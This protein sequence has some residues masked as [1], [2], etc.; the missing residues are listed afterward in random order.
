VS[1]RPF[2]DCPDT[3][4]TY[5]LLLDAM[6]AH[7]GTVLSAATSRVPGILPAC[8]GSTSVDDLL[9]AVTRTLFDHE[10]T[11]AVVAGPPADAARTADAIFARTK[12]PRVD[13]A[14]ADFL[15][16]LGGDS[17]GA[18]LDAKRGIPEY[19][20]QGATLI[21]AV[22]DVHLSRPA[23]PNAVRLSGPGI[24][25]PRPPGLSALALDEWRRLRDANDDYPLGVDAIVLAGDRLMCIPRSTRIKVTG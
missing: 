15:I 11:F 7:P 23:P 6:G 5:R 19:P 20:E 25:E 2:G 4:R 13:P 1:V 17:G 12:S 16:I 14:D 3:Q 21:Y 9:F 10:V 8:P 18:A 22:D 24:R